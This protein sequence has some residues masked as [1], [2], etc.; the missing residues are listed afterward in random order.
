MD[1]IKEVIEEN[2]ELEESNT[3]IENSNETLPIKSST[4]NIKKDTPLF[5]AQSNVNKTGSLFSSAPKKVF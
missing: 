2:P 3:V 1:L 5:T 4:A